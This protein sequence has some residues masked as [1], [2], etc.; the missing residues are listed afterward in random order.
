[1]KIDGRAIASNIRSELKDKIIQFKYKPNLSVILVG[2]DKPS[3]AYVDIKKKTGGKIGITTEIYKLPENT[4][5]SEILHLTNKLNKDPNVNGIIIQRPVPTE[6]KKEVLDMAV[7]KSKDVD[8]FR[9]DSPFDPP[10]SVAIIKI[11]EEIVGR[12][13]CKKT[14]DIDEIKK[15]LR[16]KK[17][18]V[19]GRGETGG[20]PIMKYFTKLG[21][22]YVNANS[23]T[24]NIEKLI[25]L[26]D[27]II[28]CVG[29]PNIVRHMMLKPETILIGVGMHDE[30]GK[31]C[32][33]YYEEDIKDHCAF[34][35][36]VPGGTGPVN[37]ACLFK[38]VVDAYILQH[39]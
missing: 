37:V 18:L 14:L 7:I 1:M 26:S 30:S 33:D 9:K 23:K 29:K 34:Y 13:N 8:G 24:D 2:N 20:K 21:I 17:L 11:L 16:R 19:I 28:S 27:I 38:N 39:R 35:T 25:N 4:V 32:T 12:L 3:L 31:M 22:D 36:P 15:F 6:I 10:I 5:K